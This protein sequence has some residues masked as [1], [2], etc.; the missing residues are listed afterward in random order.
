MSKIKTIRV[1]NFKAIGIQEVNL[2][3]NSIIMVAANDK[4]KSSLLRGLID[5]FQGVK[6]SVIVK[7]GEE[8]GFNEMELTDGSVIKWKFTEKGEQFS[9]TTKE[10]IT[11]TTGVLKAIGEKYFGKNF[12]IDA[13]MTMSSNKQTEKVLEILGVDTS[14]LDA[15]YKIQYDLRTDVNRELKRLL[16]LDKKKPEEVERVEIN[17]IKKRKQEIVDRNAIAQQKWLLNNEAR[18]NSIIE[19]NKIQ[20]KLKQ[21]RDKFIDVYKHLEKYEG[22]KIGEFIDFKGM[23]E[24]HKSLPKP[25]ENKSITSLEP[26][27]PESLV[28]IEEELSKAYSTREYF[29]N[30]LIELG[31]YDNWIEENKKAKDTVEELNINIA[32]IQEQ[33]TTL[34]ANA[35]LP[36][37]F[38]VSEDNEML[39]NGFPITKEQLSTSSRYIA[40]LKLGALVIGEVRALHFD[41]SFLDNISL[42]EVEKW[43]EKEGY[44]LMVERPSY[45]G[46]EITYEFLSE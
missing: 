8:K 30:F 39:Y 31:D 46:G 14:Q 9:F 43:A 5:R 13:F 11:Q 19:F 40:A 38:S 6:P 26:L 1:E 27:K 16:A 37:E 3:G 33:K 42:A 22:E 18:Q 41:A 17:E 7:Q 2:N 20:D 32:S 34:V 28:E 24:Y 10:G 35:N 25:Q 23:L 36:K 45:S 4:G 21:E 12:N 15:D 29:N 44:Q